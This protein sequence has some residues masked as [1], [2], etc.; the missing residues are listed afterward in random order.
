MTV[1]V[2][3][4]PWDSYSIDSVRV[5]KSEADAEKFVKAVVEHPN[6]RFTQGTIRVSECEVL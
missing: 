5:Y 3:A 2:V 1:Y 6:T 4:L